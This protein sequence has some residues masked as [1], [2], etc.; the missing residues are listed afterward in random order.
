MLK[1]ITKSLDKF[2]VISNQPLF[3]DLSVTER[4]LIANRS[5]IVEYNKSDIIYHEGQVKDALYVVI[6]GRVALIRAKRKHDKRD[7]IIEIL[8]K[9]DY[10]GVISLLTGHPHSVS[11][12]SLNDTRLIKIDY[13]VFKLIVEK[14]PRL[15]LYLSKT[16]SRRLREKNIGKKKIFQSTILAVYAEGDGEMAYYYA[17]TL[18][19]Q[20]SKESAKRAITVILSKKE[21]GRKE[22]D[23]NERVQLDDNA[24]KAV[25]QLS[26]LASEYHFVII[27]LPEIITDRERTILR[28][29]DLC[30]I[31]LDRS[32]IGKADRMTMLFKKL[33]VVNDETTRLICRVRKD[34]KNLYANK[35]HA[36]YA[37]L[38]DDKKETD[39]TI[40]RIAREISGVLVGLALGSGGAL[41]LSEIGVLQVLEREKIPIDIIAGTSIGALIAALWASGLSAKEVEKICGTF[42][43]MAKTIGLFDLTIPKRG[44]VSGNNI[45]KF[46]QKHLGNKTFHDVRMPL[47]IV[48]CDINKRKEVVIKQGKLVDAIMASIAIPGVFNPFV[49]ADG[50]LLVDGGIINPVPVNV[51]SR[52]G[53]KRIIAVNSMPSPEDTMK[54][55]AKS[56]TIID[57]II[58]SFYAMEYRIGKH[59]CLEADI[60]LHP[61]LNNTAWY[62]FYRIKEFVKF[63]RTKTEEALGDIEK[64]VK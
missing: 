35:K 7:T 1:E 12:K 54:L 18:R 29:A 42:N 40:R 61:I 31:I 25:S 60:S 6:T 10:F 38:S 64:L 45:R 20:I 57:I 26:S 32:L 5:Q 15:S 24:R 48:A 41:G 62:E 13:L 56:Q 52:E 2:L 4:A 14:I 39:K 43:T 51:L 27:S 17:T 34:D 22:R 3:Q 28:Q 8:R 11:V 59:A 44:F 9:G 47:R 53:V 33:N 23:R 49:M 36:I 46:L 50:T 37:T 30:H 58:N 55:I 19:Q 16:I 63:G 21:K